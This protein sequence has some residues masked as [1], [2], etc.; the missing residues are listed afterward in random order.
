M[1]MNKVRA[2]TILASLLSAASCF[3]AEV[4]RGSL[5]IPQRLGNITLHHSEDGFTIR[6]QGIDVPVKSYMVDKKLRGVSP[7]DLSKILVNGG[8]IAVENRSGSDYSL[9]FQGRVKGGGP[10]GATVGAIAGKAAVHGTA[11]VV[12]LGISGLVGWFC[13]PAAPAVYAML[14][15]T[16]ATP[17]ELASNVAAVAGGIALGTLTGPA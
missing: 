12:Y 9:Q 6:D 17:V 7:K 14:Q 4:D 2:L 15:A 16:F 10:V 5:Q 13:P 1:F 3:S 11:Q 8:Y